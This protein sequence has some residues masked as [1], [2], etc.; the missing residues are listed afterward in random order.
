MLLCRYQHPSIES[1]KGENSESSNGASHGFPCELTING[2]AKSTAG[3][4]PRC[5]R[6]FTCHSR[7]T[8]ARALV[9]LSALELR[10]AEVEYDLNS[11][12]IT[13]WL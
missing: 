2:P 13:D 11:G 7:C 9:A 6:S 8:S 12:L 1:S 10:I 5:F 4:K 3:S